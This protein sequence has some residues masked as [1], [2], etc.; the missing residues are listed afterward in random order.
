VTASQRRTVTVVVA[1]LGVAFLMVWATNA[2][3]GQVILEQRTPSVTEQAEDAAET[4]ESSEDRGGTEDSGRGR[5]PADGSGAWVRDVTA[6]V[7]LVAGLL[8]TGLILRQLL[9]RLRGRLAEERLDV[10]LEP[11]PHLE[12]ARAALERDQQR[13]RDALA[14]SD[15]R[16]GIVACWVVFEEA[17]A[18]A[19][20][21][22]QPAETASAFVVR[23][24]HLLDV[25]PRPV[26]ALARLF[27]EARFS[28]HPMGADAR[29][30]AERALRAI[31]LDLAHSGAAP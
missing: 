3:G 15:V 9:I 2:G 23:F 13:Q 26:G 28:S 7:L 20:V 21:D 25:D 31:H 4:T 1:A 18:A 8:V 14:G 12:T 29:A 16:N 10:P 5:P 17:A 30:H 11:L 19:G 6:F 22:R 27:L 24:L